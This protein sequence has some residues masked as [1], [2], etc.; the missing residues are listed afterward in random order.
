MNASACRNEAWSS[1]S[2]MRVFSLATPPS[3]LTSYPRIVEAVRAR[4]PISFRRAP[5]YIAVFR[6]LPRPFVLDVASFGGTFVGERDAAEHALAP[7]GILRHASSLLFAG[8]SS[9]G[10]SLP[11]RVKQKVAP[12]PT[13]PSAHTS[14]P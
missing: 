10:R 12:S 6:T 5:H 9:A 3:P 11:P 7:A 2:K 14:P 13:A 1:T 8:A 4:A